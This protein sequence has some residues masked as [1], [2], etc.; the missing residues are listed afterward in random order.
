MAETE[1]LATTNGTG[2]V[3]GAREQIEVENPATGEVAGSVP[4]MLPEDVA[5][6]VSRARRA[7]PGWEALGFAGRA[8]VL[9]RAQAWV[10]NNSDRIIQ[11]IVSETGKTWEDAQLAEVGYAAPAFGFWAKNAE[12]YLADEKIRS[13]LAVPAGPQGRGAL[14]PRGRGGRDRPLELPADQQLR[15]LHPR[16]GRR[17]RGGA[18]AVGGHAADLAA[19]GRVPGGVAACRATSTRC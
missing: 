16:A 13:A 7:Q 12:K 14:P 9:K 3:D 15:R 5:E 17:Q 1:T 6:M 10:I 4:R 19:H 11:T 8:R 2:D 18:Q